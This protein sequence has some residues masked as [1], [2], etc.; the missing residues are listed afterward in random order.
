[1]IARL[2][3]KAHQLD[4]WL[5][6]HVG[7]L[8]TAIL[9]WGLVLT[10]IETFRAIGRDLESD[11]GNVLTLL[12]AVAFQL[13]LLINQLAQWHDLRERRRRRSAARSKAQIDA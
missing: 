9:A 11:S 10:I 4:A 3:L 13:A 12:F 6:E 2:V 8:Y 1:M 7:R 5:H